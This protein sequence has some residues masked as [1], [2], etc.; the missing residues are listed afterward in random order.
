MCKGEREHGLDE[1]E[2]LSACGA[3]RRVR[4]RRKKWTLPQSRVF[5]W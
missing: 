3:A 2:L 5:L 4:L 1:A